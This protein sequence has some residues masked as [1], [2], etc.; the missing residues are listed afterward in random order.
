M[1]LD[2][3][4]NPPSEELYRK[5]FPESSIMTLKSPFELIINE[6][7]S[8]EL[9]IGRR[10]IVL[11]TGVYSTDDIK[12]IVV[13]DLLTLL[14]AIDFTQN[15]VNVKNLNEL[16]NLKEPLKELIG[17]T[18]I[19]V[20]EEQISK[21]IH[22]ESNTLNNMQKFCLIW[23]EAKKTEAEYHASQLISLAPELK[24]KIFSYIPLVGEGSIKF[25]D[26]ESSEN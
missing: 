8:L 25:M 3:F 6:G 1:L 5:H 19:D 16:L 2:I 21:I 26:H 14:D 4:T 23:D 7:H 15:K 20:S 11:K 13:E 12:Y 10:S 22:L 24:N 17:T 18:K 9:M